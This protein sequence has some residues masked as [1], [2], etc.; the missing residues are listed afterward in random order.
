[1]EVIETHNE[2]HLGGGDL[3]NGFALGFEGL[4]LLVAELTGGPS[5]LQL[6]DVGEGVLVYLGR[7]VGRLDGVVNPGD[8]LA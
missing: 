8:K 5:A 7:G 4:Y 2:A 6:A 3:G 1:M